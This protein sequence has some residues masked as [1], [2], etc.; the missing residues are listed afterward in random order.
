YAK[1]VARRTLVPTPRDQLD[2]SCEG[3]RKRVFSRRNSPTGFP[4]A[5][6]KVVYKDYEF[7]EEQLAVSYSEEHTFC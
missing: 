2:M 4:I 6:A 5:F 7:I 3:I 1:D